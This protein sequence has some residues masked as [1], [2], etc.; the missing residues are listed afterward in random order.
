MP[1]LDTDYVAYFAARAP[2]V[3]DWFPLYN[4]PV[5]Q[6]PAPNYDN[7]VLTGPLMEWS[8]NKQEIERMDL[9]RRFFDWR[10]YY[11]QTMAARILESRN[12]MAQEAL[13]M[14]F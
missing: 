3:P 9:E 2:E 1:S 14:D 10:I 11:G 6:R 13:S 7:S 8:R 5:P 12:Q 4:T